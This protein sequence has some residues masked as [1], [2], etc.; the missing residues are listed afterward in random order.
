MASLTA[1]N[2]ALLDAITTNDNFGESFRLSS[3]YTAQ[4]QAA[5]GTV[6]TLCSNTGN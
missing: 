4:L 1:V 2:Q 3:Q 6:A 5:T